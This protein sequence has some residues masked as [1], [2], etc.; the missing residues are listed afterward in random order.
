M[1]S[2]VNND[3]FIEEAGRLATYGPKLHEWPLYKSNLNSAHIVI[4]T[5]CLNGSKEFLH[6][7]SRF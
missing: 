7:F 5:C 6:L 1:S 3:H 2:Q 4:S